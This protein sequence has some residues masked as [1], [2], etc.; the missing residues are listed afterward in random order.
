MR[1]SFSIGFLT[2]R[3][4][5]EYRHTSDLPISGSSDSVQASIVFLERV[6]VGR[7]GSTPRPIFGLASRSA[8]AAEALADYTLECESE[9]R[10][11]LL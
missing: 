5:V 8:P 6:R 4:E 7:S 11:C 9:I 1:R 2:L 10:K 3:F